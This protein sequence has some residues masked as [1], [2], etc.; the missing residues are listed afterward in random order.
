MQEETNVSRNSAQGTIR[1]LVLP[2]SNAH[3]KRAF[4]LAS[5]LKDDTRNRM[6]LPLLSSIMD[7]AGLG[8]KIGP[9]I[10]LVQAA[11]HHFELYIY[12]Y[13][14]IQEEHVPAQ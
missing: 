11:H 1:L 6:G 14:Y 13:I 2:V 7:R 12:I 9:G 3:V 4:F 10:F 5:L 8:Q